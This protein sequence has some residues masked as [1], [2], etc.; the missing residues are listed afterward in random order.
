MAE[1]QVTHARNHLR[2]LKVTSTRNPKY[3]LRSFE[4]SASETR[5]LDTE[6]NV[7]KDVK[8]TFDYQTGTYTI[9]AQSS[10]L[11]KYVTYQ[12]AGNIMRK[13]RDKARD[14][15]KDRV[16]E[17]RV[18]RCICNCKVDEVGCL[19]PFNAFKSA[20]PRAPTK[21]QATGESES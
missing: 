4:I 9:V 5:Q 17:Q 21:G 14:S 8:C 2:N 15:A 18:C 16:T 19:C 3:S 12:V 13:L 20:A 6:P 1:P 10:L 7:P 11:V